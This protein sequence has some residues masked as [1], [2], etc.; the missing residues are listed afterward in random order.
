VITSVASSPI[1]RHIAG[2]PS[3]SSP[4]TYEPAGAERLRR[5]D[6]LDPRQHRRGGRAVAVKGSK[7]AGGIVRVTSRTFLVHLDQQRV[8]VAIDVDALHLLDVARHLALAPPGRARAGPEVREAGLEGRGH[9][10]AIHPGDHQHVAGVRFLH[11]GGDQALRVE[12]QVVD[13]HGVS[14]TS[15]PRSCR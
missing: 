7:E 2:S 1:L 9:G 10:G 4:P 13:G 5:D 3:A 12:P 14:R 15:T 11:H 8:G 6:V